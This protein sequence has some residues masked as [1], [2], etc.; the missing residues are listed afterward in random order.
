MRLYAA[1]S[2]PA[3]ANL[4]LNAMLLFP[5][6]WVTSVLRVTSLPPPPIPSP[7]PT[8]ASALHVK[9]RVPGRPAKAFSGPVCSQGP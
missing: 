3:A 5:H 4:L 8:P 1:S 7:H 6:A 9:H 2:L